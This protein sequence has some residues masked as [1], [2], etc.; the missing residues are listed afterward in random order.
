MD[1]SIRMAMGGA[2]P[3]V[4]YQPA[5]TRGNNLL[6]IL[7]QG[8]GVYSQWE[9]SERDRDIDDLYLERYRSNIDELPQ[10]VEVLRQPLTTGDDTPSPKGMDMNTIGMIAG[11]VL[12][13][14]IAARLV[15]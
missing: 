13:G 9:Q 1:E 12:L 4:V 6:D 11:L 3:D 8:M 7:S 10:R 15:V 14:V 2:A 5:V